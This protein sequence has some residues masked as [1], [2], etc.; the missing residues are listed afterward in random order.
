MPLPLLDRI[1][2][3]VSP[4]DGKMA[5]LIA[6]GFENVLLLTTVAGPT[7]TPFPGL[8]CSRPVLGSMY[9]ALRLPDFSTDKQS[10][11]ESR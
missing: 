4:S 1:G 10:C 7:D 11:A 6:T 8:S 2:T 3:S 9:S 5:D